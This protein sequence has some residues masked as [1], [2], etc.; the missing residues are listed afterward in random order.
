VGEPLGF[1]VFRRGLFSALVFLVA[2][3]FSSAQTPI[4]VVHV[5][6]SLADNQHQGIVPVSARLGNGDDPGGNLYWGAAFGVKTFFKSRKDWELISANPGPSLAVLERCVF[7]HRGD[8]VYVVADAYQGSKMREAATDFLLAA[9]GRNTATMVVKSG[10]ANVSLITAGGADLVV[11]VGH[12]AFMD[13]QIPPVAAGN[14][15]NSRTAIILACASKSYFANY[16]KNTGAAPLLW[17][18]GLMAPE[19][20][21]LKAALDG[22]IAREDGERIRERAA[23]A[24]DKYQ[25]CGLRGAQRLFATGW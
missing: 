19:A 13:F 2:P 22:W 1:Q 4:R 23:V 3:H 5:Y 11:Y 18:T 10:D 20:Y 15:K 21:T 25:H 12:D 9:A 7:K 14:S 16:L 17:T 24:Y 6:V 8:L